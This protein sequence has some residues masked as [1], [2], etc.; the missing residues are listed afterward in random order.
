MPAA[1]QGQLEA[2]VRL[3][4]GADDLHADEDLGAKTQRLLMGAAGQLCTANALREARVV[5]DP[6]AGSRL[7]PRSHAFENDRAQ[8]FGGGVDR[9]GEPSRARPNDDDVVQVALRLRAQPG[10]AREFAAPLRAPQVGLCAVRR[11]SRRH[12]HPDMLLTDGRGGRW[13]TPDASWAGVNEFLWRRQLGAVGE[14]GDGSLDTELGMLPQEPT[15]RISVDIDPAMG[16]VITGQEGPRRQ[17]RRR[18][19]RANHRHDRV[20]AAQCA[21]A[22]G[23]APGIA[24]AARTDG[25]RLPTRVVLSTSVT[26]LI[27]R[28]TWPMAYL[29]APGAGIIS[30]ERADARRSRGGS[31]ATGSGGERGRDEPSCRAV[32][33]D[34][35]TAD[36]VDREAA[37]GRCD[38]AIRAIGRGL[39]TAVLAALEAAS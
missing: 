30:A 18:R 13:L 3:R 35:H 36:R 34:G 27:A 29:T 2:A 38:V 16:H 5:L 10:A 25:P 31:R 28:L 12:R 21:P 26:S 22:T 15:H 24:S 8:S 37:V 14:H 1:A 4:F 11:R 9:S 33:V 19:A 23:R 39:A 6:R 20:A 7:A 32:W 17:H